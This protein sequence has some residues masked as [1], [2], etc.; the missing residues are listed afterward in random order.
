[1]YRLVLLRQQPQ[2]MEMSLRHGSLTRRSIVCNVMN[3]SYSYSYCSSKRP[4]SKL[5]DDRK[6]SNGLERKERQIMKESSDYQEVLFKTAAMSNQMPFGLSLDFIRE[7]WESTLPKYNRVSAPIEA[8]ETLYVLDEVLPD[9]HKYIQSPNTAG[10]RVE[11]A[12]FLAAPGWGKTSILAII[13]LLALVASGRKQEGEVPPMIKNTVKKMNEKDRLALA[14]CCPICITFNSV[15]DIYNDEDEGSDIELAIASRMAYSYLADDSIHFRMFDREFRKCVDKKKCPRFA[16]DPVKVTL[17]TIANLA[18][19]VNKETKLLL[20]VDEANR[21]PGKGKKIL[22]EIREAALTL[23]NSPDCRVIFTGLT[24]SWMRAADIREGKTT[25]GYP[26]W[27]LRTNGVPVSMVIHPIRERLQDEFQLG[28]D[29]AYAI[30]EYI[31]ALASG[32]FRTLNNITKDCLACEKD[33][34]SEFTKKIIVDR[35][36]DPIIMLDVLAHSVLDSKLAWMEILPCQEIIAYEA[37][38]EDFIRDCLSY[39]RGKNSVKV[40]ASRVPLEHLG[41]LIGVLGKEDST[42]S[43][44]DVSIVNILKALF[45]LGRFDNDLNLRSTDDDPTAFEVFTAYTMIL[46]LWAYERINNVN[47]HQLCLVAEDKPPEPNPELKKA[48][49]NAALASALCE[50]GRTCNLREVARADATTLERIKAE[51]QKE[52]FEPNDAN[53]NNV[54]RHY[55]TFAQP[56]DEELAARAHVL[57]GARRVGSNGA[58]KT[59]MIR[60]PDFRNCNDGSIVP[61]LLQLPEAEDFVSENKPSCFKD[62]L[63]GA[64]ELNKLDGVLP[65]GSVLLPGS[66]IN[67][68]LDS[69]VLFEKEGGGHAL[70]AIEN[71][72]IPTLEKDVVESKL[73]IFMDRYKDR[74]FVCSGATDHPQKAQDLGLPLIYE[75]DVVYVFVSSAS[76]KVNDLSDV[77]LSDVKCQVLHASASSF[78]GPSLSLLPVPARR[79]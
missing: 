76:T 4:F 25:S 28:K 44:F 55:V 67:P 71:K 10:D 32:R 37:A 77:D 50:I 52:K 42:V 11:F 61:R 63:D 62:L 31:I 27:I 72:R 38:T 1:M 21:I 13:E 78:F 19:N 40:L 45:E 8:L 54:I 56:D 41:G 17:N 57:R 22:V 24:P 7:D 68:G 73:K 51:L 12:A 26:V 30:A 47:H 79:H 3:S 58:A 43:N 69:I 39:E 35:N 74:L 5:L 29:K 66:P 15:M 18:T 23:S 49:T 60:R 53:I 33:E 46:K 20:L 16:N 9:I 6:G 75:E 34:L 2:V 36:M 48:A 64:K 14:A 65:G 59:I 70:L